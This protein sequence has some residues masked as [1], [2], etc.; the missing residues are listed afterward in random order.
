MK[1]SSKQIV[2]IVRSPVSLMETAEFRPISNHGER[3]R[4]SFARQEGI[5]E[6]QKCSYILLNFGARMRG[7]IYFR[8]RPFCPGKEPRYLVNRRFGP[9]RRSRRFLEDKNLYRLPVCC[10]VCRLSGSYEFHCGRKFGLGKFS[11]RGIP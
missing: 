11:F 6:E 4:C 5:A 8:P 1:A 3:R 7:V 10:I 2:L 9:Q